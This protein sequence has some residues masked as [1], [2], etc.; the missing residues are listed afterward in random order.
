MSYTI[1]RYE[2]T[3]MD[4]LEVNLDNIIR[5]RCKIGRVRMKWRPQVPTQFIPAEPLGPTWSVLRPTSVMDH[6]RNCLAS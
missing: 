2:A 1:V 5:R 4:R 6:P 3:E